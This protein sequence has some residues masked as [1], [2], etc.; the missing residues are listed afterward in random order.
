MELLAATDWA[1]VSAWAALATVVVYVVLG[2]FAWRQIREARRLR[3]EQARLARSSQEEQARLARESWAEQAR[4]SRQLQ[5]E[6][7]R[8][9][10][11]VDF[12]PGFL[13][14]LVVENI[15]RTMARN[16]SITTD[17]PFESTLNTP[18]ELNETP[19]FRDSIPA[20]PPRK[21]IRI[22]FDSAPARFESDLPRAYDVTVRYQGPS[23]QQYEPDR[24]PLDLSMYLG[25]AL[26]PKGLPDLVDE[27]EK[28][29]KEL[30]KWTDGTRGLRVNAVDRERQ[31]NAELHRYL[32]RRF[33]RSARTDGIATA[34]RI[35][36]RDRLLR[37]L[38][39][40]GFR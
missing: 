35:F 36:A 6:Q 17:K 28:I 16:V 13:I 33:M 38:A 19:L 39:R 25:S 18:H 7:A 23:G 34:A 26:P 27:V 1:A 21:K 37:A 10:V 22:L 8:P 31:E 4:Q 29:R 30:A 3:E 2:V 20:L 14:Y 9:F 15:G 12:E 24:Y 11:I 32:T 40:R 5:E